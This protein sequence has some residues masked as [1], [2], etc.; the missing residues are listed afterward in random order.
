MGCGHV[1]MWCVFST[2]TPHVGHSEC[3]CSF[4]RRKFFPVPQNSAFHLT[5]S[6]CF[7]DEREVKAEDI[8]SQAMEGEYEVG[9]SIFF[10]SKIVWGILLV[11]N[12]EIDVVEK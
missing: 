3:C 8:T 5:T 7:V 12:R 11:Q 2:A 4:Q 9:I 1:K 10:P 6:V